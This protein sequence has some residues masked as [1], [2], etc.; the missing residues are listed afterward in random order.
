MYP[1]EFLRRERPDYPVEDV[2]DS[3]VL[4]LLEVNARTHNVR[5]V[6]RTLSELIAKTKMPRLAS[7]TQKQYL[8]MLDRVG[9]K[10]VRCLGKMT[11][12]WIQEA[13]AKLERDVAAETKHLKEVSSVDARLGGDYSRAL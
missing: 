12:Y 9:K 3:I 8:E 4:M 1:E 11:R 7:R 13:K 10:R 2:H 5:T 6:V